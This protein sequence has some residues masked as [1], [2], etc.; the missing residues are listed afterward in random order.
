MAVKCKGSYAESSHQARKQKGFPFYWKK[1]MIDKLLLYTLLYKSAIRT[2]NTGLTMD[3]VLLQ[4]LFD[5][6]REKLILYS[7]WLSGH[8]LIKDMHS[9]YFNT[10]LFLKNTSFYLK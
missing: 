3:F 5:N 6:E 10:V 9:C 7:P 4:L 8:K 2:V 1:I